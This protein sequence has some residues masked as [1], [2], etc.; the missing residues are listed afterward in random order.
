[1]KLNDK[2]ILYVPSGEKENV[3]L[4]KT[5]HLCIAAHQDDIE[6]MAFSGIAECF[7]SENKH[8]CGVV[9][10]DGAGSPRGGAYKDFSNE[11]IK[12]IRLNEQKNAADIGKYC[13]QILLNY[14][15]QQVKDKSD[16][17]VIA[18][19]IEIL[20]ATKP[21]TVYL[22][23]LADKHPTHVATAIKGI[24]AMRALD[25]K[26]KPK[27]V[28]GC[29][30]WRD[31]DWMNDDEKILLDCSDN[32]TLFRKLSN[33]FT[34]QIE[35]GKRY[36]IAIEGRRLANATL[37]NSNCID[38]YSSLNYAMDLT[39]LIY[40][41]NTDITEYVLAYIERFADTVKNLLNMFNC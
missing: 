24:K 11:E 29:E 15:S 30:V 17:Q 20:K 34:S 10:C 31:L 32:Q 1:M 40:D 13:C 6:F 12:A 25:K 22:H 38:R 14:S 26:D 9:T 33:V 2:A 23:N 16:G 27:A 5:T 35:S 4:R 36:D 19:Y 28:Y 39:P 7:G 8:F 21:Q 41:K 37:L 18:D 3:V